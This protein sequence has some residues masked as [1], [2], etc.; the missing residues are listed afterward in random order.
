VG[1]ADSAYRFRISA[2]SSDGTSVGK[3]TKL[4]TH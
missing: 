3:P 4:K 2:S 1:A